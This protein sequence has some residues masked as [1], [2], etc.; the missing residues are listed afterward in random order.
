MNDLFKNGLFQKAL[1][2]GLDFAL[3]AGEKLQTLVAE[4]IEKG[5]TYQETRKEKAE[6]AEETEQ[7]TETQTAEAST[8][9][10]ESEKETE[11]QSEAKTSRWE[12]YEHRLRK[13]VETAISK[14]NFIRN[15]D[16]ERLEARI[17]ALEEKMAKIAQQLAEKADDSQKQ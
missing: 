4:A 8:D 5:K 7:E 11:T 12:E 3:T 1:S 17:I 14:F 15:D 10:E 2:T 16:H 13:L 6:K 9:S